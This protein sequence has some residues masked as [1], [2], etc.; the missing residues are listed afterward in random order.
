MEPKISYDRDGAAQGVLLMVA[1]RGAI[2]GNWWSVSGPVGS[3]IAGPQLLG[4]VAVVV[5]YR[6]YRLHGA[7]GPERPRGCG[8]GAYG[9]AGL[10]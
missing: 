6:L 9:A 10:M 5:P 4:H 7:A 1:D 2:R 8:K 3:G